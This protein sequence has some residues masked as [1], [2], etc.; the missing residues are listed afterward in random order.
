MPAGPDEGGFPET[1]LARAR[2]LQSSST[3]AA[4]PDSSEALA[5]L[6][7]GTVSVADLDDAVLE[8]CLQESGAEAVVAALLQGARARRAAEPAAAHEPV[9]FPQGDAVQAR[10]R[11]V[12]SGIVGWLAAA[13]VLA[14]AAWA[15]FLGSRPRREPAPEP[16]VESA[17]QPKR[18]EAVALQWPDTVPFDSANLKPWSSPQPRLPQRLPDFRASGGATL[19]GSGDSRFS[20]W[21]EATVIVRLERGWGSG[22][23]ISADGWLL[24]NYHVIDSVAQ[25]AAVSGGTPAVEI[26]TGRSAGGRIAPQPALRA[27]VYRVDP[28]RDLALLKLEALPAA[29]KAVPFFPLARTVDEGEDCYVIGSQNN[30]PAWWIRSG[31]VS[32]VFDFPEGLS[33]FAAGAE[34]RDGHIERERATVV[35]TDTRI[36]GGDSGG[37]LLNVKG[38]L[39]GLTF[40][41][42]A[43]RSAGSV[44]WHIALEHV[45]A[46]VND[47]PAKDEGVPFD[48]WTAGLPSAVVLEPELAD[49]DRDGRIDSL[50]YRYGLLSPENPRAAPRPAAITVYI[51]FSQR[52]S[53]SDREADRLPAGLWGMED[54][55]RFRFDT[56]V[57]ARADGV[58]AVGYTSP[59][60]IVDEI[61][62][63]PA[64]QP[65]AAVVWRREGN[66]RW[67]GTRTDRA[68]PLVDAA[69]IG[70][71]SVARLSTIA[72]QLVAPGS[73]PQGAPDK[74]SPNVVR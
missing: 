41:T 49:G 12:S 71:A 4:V 55:G 7:E 73:P 62:I 60:G 46:F 53:R 67:F 48:A 19:G 36:S 1:I 35:V 63:G 72:G 34:R 3:S 52:S 27:R 26:I 10:R 6:A 37:P 15:A 58:M 66:G 65:T 74:R 24:S 18:E 20:R 47:L 21:R 50:R 13:A 61:R 16:F 31:T 39:I 22:A 64:R 33:Q 57:T 70:A 38:E 30:G 51:D 11:F 54:R 32:Q 23:F 28:A 69:R 5:A 29:V 42:P 9:V 25:Q 56:F 44:G 43:N 17:P 14:L 8:G 59:Q 40:A 68:V 45:R 2:E